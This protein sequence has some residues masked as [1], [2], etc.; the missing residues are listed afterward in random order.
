MQRCYSKSLSEAESKKN[1]ALKI[2]IQELGKNVGVLGRM[3]ENYLEVRMSVRQ[4]AGVELPEPVGE[5]EGEGSLVLQMY[6]SV[7]EKA[8][9]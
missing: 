7:K 1:N 2:F 6:Q 3:A 5:L 4:E 9:K 8:K